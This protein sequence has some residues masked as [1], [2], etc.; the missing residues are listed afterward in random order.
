MAGGTWK[1]QN[2]IRPGA[3]INFKAVPAPNSN[4]GTR[5]IMTMPVAMSWGPEKGVIELLSTDLLDGKSLSKIGYTG[6]DSESLVFRLALSNCYKALIYRLDVGGTKATGESG[7]VT[8]VAKYPG[9]LGNSIH[10]V[11]TENKYD[12]QY[13]DV[14]TLFKGAEKFRQTLL[15]TAEVDAMED[16]DYIEWSGTGTLTATA[17]AGVAL[18]GGTNGSVSASAYSA[19][20]GYFNAVKGLNWNVMAIPQGEDIATDSIKSLVVSLITNLRDEQ[21]KKVQAV[22]FNK[23]SNYEGIISVRQGFT[24]LTETITP[25]LF[26]AYAAGLTAGAEVDESNTYKAIDDATGIVYMTGE[27]AYDNEK[28]IEMINKGQFILTTRQDGTI[29]VEQ[30]INTLHPPYPSADVNYSFT[31]NR[32]IRTLDEINNSIKLLFETSYIGKVDNND[33]GRNVFKADII[34]YL[35]I[36]Q[37]I[38]A[39]QN[40]DSSTDISVSAGTAIDAVVVDLAIQPVDSMEKLYMTVNVG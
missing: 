1:A 9:I 27:V 38:G 36:L 37:G 4:L 30:D 21:G 24:T 16:N 26:T 23:F 22:L 39:I 40:F 10:F 35:N 19:D 18:T 3:Y 33:D 8:A 20:D 14:I 11:I 5:G 2:K 34:S 25:E 13:W 15:K 32:V 28:V 7:N 12:S 6:A 31:K 29:I 17:T